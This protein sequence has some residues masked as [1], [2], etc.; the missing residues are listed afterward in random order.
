MDAHIIPNFAGYLPYLTNGLKLLTQAGTT[1]TVRVEG[2]DF[3]LNNAKII[4]SNLI[5]ENGVAHVLDQVR[6]VFRPFLSLLSSPF[7][8]WCNGKKR[9]VYSTFGGLDRGMSAILN[10]FLF[11]IPLS[12]PVPQPLNKRN[13]DSVDSS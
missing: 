13:G 3:Y 2:S 11:A 10:S 7:L 5:L 4:A 12:F 9:R 6:V 8:P 1:V